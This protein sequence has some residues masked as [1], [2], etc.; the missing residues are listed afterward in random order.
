MKK[1]FSVTSMGRSAFATWLCLTQFDFSSG[2]LEAIDR[3]FVKE[4][5]AEGGLFPYCKDHEGDEASVS[6]LSEPI[7]TS[8]PIR[9]LFTTIVGGKELMQNCQRWPRLLYQDPFRNSPPLRDSF[10]RQL[11]PFSLGRWDG[12]LFSLHQ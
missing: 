1:L 10:L 5:S 11:H 7:Q 2:R 3:D 6:I 12:T 9:S 4:K 8:I